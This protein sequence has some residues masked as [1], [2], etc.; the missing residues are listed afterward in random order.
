MPKTIKFTVELT[1]SESVKPNDED[2]QTMVNNV[3]N[4]LNHT[5]GEI[6]LTPEGADYYVT[7]INVSE[8]FSGAK[9]IVNIL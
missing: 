6:G 9:E 2:I 3:A 5:A 1:F 7:D 4:S 8:H